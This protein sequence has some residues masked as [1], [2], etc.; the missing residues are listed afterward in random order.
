MVGYCAG[1]AI[2]VVPDQP[3]AMVYAFL[4]T[5][6]V[7]WTTY[8]LFPYAGRLLPG[9]GVLLFVL[10]SIPSSGGAIPPS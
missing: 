7:A 4:T 9:V 8:G 1:L 10:L 3:L 2:A 5:Q 6:A